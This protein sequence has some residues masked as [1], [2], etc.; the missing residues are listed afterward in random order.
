MLTQIVLP[1]SFICIA[2]TV[3]L[4]APGF[5]DLPELE[6]TPAQ[7]WPLTEKEGGLSLPYNY[8][9]EETSRY[10]KCT[11]TKKGIEASS[12]EIAKTLK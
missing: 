9:L 1:A 2:M 11:E 8:D 3:A 7:F 4:S 5:F 12:V 10:N 6:L